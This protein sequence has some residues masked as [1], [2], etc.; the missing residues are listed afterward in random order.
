MNLVDHPVLVLAIALAGLCAAAFAGDA[1]RARVRPVGSGERADLDI[2]LTASLTLL[3]LLLGFT[4]S[5]AVSRYD[6]RKINEAAETNAIA[7]EYR[8]ADL[9]DAPG[10]TQVRE[11]LTRYTDERIHV[12]RCRRYR[13]A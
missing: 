9:L 2:V 3:G 13:G 6:Q 1:L 4:F 5:M 12:A 7:A 11:L 10:R 8:R